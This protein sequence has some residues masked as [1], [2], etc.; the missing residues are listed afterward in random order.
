[1]KKL[2]VD[3]ATC[4]GCGT[5]AALCP[6]VFKMTDEVKAE[7]TDQTADT[8]ENIQSAIDSCPATAIFWEEE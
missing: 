4:I 2:V 7:V 6:K 5:C 3:Q 1:M 8:T